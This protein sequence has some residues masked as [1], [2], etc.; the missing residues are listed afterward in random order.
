[1]S[2]DPPTWPPWAFK[3]RS[4]VALATP[5]D[6][7][8][9]SRPSDPASGPPRSSLWAVS[10]PWR[11]ASTTRSDEQGRGKPARRG[12]VKAG[13]GGPYIYIYIYALSVYFWV[14]LRLTQNYTKSE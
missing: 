6:P 5:A 3:A 13:Q 2:S 8:P 4:S 1:M 14:N 11:W 7:E 10:S 9:R 12:G